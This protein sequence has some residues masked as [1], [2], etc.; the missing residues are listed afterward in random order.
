MIPN[1][2]HPMIEK[3][4]IAALL[5][6]QPSWFRR[7]IKKLIAQD[8]MPAPLPGGRWH[9]AKLMRW[10]ETYG[11]MKAIANGKSLTQIRIQYDRDLLTAKYAAHNEAGRAA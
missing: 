5:G 8:G 2:E 7:Q 11:E 1:E 6:W 9:R 3:A 4:E 10:I